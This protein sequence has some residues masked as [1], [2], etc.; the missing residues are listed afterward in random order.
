MYA[1]RPLITA[2]L[3]ALAAIHPVLSQSPPGF[4]PSVSEHLGVMY[5]GT[6]VSPAGITLLG[7]ST[8]VLFQI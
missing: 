5:N 6:D 3:A 2:L 7:T 1:P 8:P 4:V